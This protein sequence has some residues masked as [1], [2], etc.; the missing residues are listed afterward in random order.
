MDEPTLL[1]AGRLKA[2]HRV[3]LADAVIAAFA[4]RRAAVLMH[5]DPE[6]EALTGLLPM[7]SLPYKSFT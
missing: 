3:S 2:D 1:T 4:I 5:K 6:F 7:E